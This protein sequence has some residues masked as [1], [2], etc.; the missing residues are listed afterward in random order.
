[1][2]RSE[3][4]LNETPAPHSGVD[5]RVVWNEYWKRLLQLNT[6]SLAKIEADRKERRAA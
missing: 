5:C 3:A 1:M 2:G 6:D 4:F